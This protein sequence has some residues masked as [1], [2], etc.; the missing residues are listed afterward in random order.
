MCV[1]LVAHNADDDDLRM[2][3]V[4]SKL[5]EITYPKIVIL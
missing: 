1:V 5:L 3:M 2:M 4:I